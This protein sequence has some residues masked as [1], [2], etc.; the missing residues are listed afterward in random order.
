MVALFGCLDSDLSY[1]HGLLGQTPLGPFT[2]EHLF[3]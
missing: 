1:L 2:Y 3:F